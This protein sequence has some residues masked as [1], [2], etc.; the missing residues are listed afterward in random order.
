MNE[1]MVEYMKEVCTEVC[2]PPA[3]NASSC[4]RSVTNAFG[5]LGGGREY[6]YRMYTNINI[7]K[8]I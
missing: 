4:I 7:S 3:R 6:V 2:V 5:L 1:E 8:H